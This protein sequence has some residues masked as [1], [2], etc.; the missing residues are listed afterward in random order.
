[1][2][3]DAPW[4]DRELTADQ[5]HALA[6]AERQ[7]LA[8]TMRELRPFLR[9]LRWAFLRDAHRLTRVMRGGRP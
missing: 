1:M 7:G 6:L 2:T 9:E 5:A 8:G 3:A 4:S